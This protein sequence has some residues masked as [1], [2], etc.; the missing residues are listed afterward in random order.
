MK[1]FLSIIIVVV[2]IIAS[3]FAL[4]NLTT[5]F[6]HNIYLEDYVAYMGRYDS[7]NVRGKIVGIDSKPIDCS[8]GVFEF[9]Q[10]LENLRL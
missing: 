10:K 5:V 6:E 1:R 9:H 3:Y 7:I 4:N 2:C 8:E